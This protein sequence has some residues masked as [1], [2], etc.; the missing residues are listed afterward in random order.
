M[1]RADQSDL[2]QYGQMLR[3]RLAGRSDVV[4]HRESTEQLE[5]GLGL[6]LAE[7]V[8][9][10]AP[11]WVGQGLVDVGHSECVSLGRRLPPIN[12]EPTATQRILSARPRNASRRLHI[13]S[14][15]PINQGVTGYAGRP[16]RKQ[17]E[18]KSDFESPSS[19]KRRN[20]TPMPKRFLR[21]LVSIASLTEAPVSNTR[22]SKVV[23]NAWRSGFPWRVHFGFRRTKVFVELSRPVTRDLAN[24]IIHPTSRQKKPGWRHDVGRTASEQGRD[25]RISRRP[26]SRTFFN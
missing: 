12:D 6:A 18:L 13:I 9:D 19:T 4:V 20:S 3:H 7:L 14:G 17:I 24:R 16:L 10:D 23:R 2:L 15:E 22:L 1:L 25:D 5:E 8:Q 21:Q 26:L 11:R